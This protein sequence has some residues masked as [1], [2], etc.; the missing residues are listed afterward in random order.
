MARQTVS[1]IQDYLKSRGIAFSGMKR[2]ERSDIYEKAR[3]FNILV[4]P[5][6][7]TDDRN[8]ILSDKLC[9]DGMCL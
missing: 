8:E 1:E 4:D 9:V 5:D 6:G 3:A 2:E 7:L